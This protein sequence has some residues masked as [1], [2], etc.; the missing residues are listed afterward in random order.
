MGYFANGTQNEIFRG[1]YCDHCIH[2]REQD[3]PI[4]LL[5]LMW[6]YE[7]FK[8]HTQ[9]RPNGVQTTKRKALA[10][11]IP[12]EKPGEP[13]E[14]KMF[15]AYRNTE[16]FQVEVAHISDVDRLKAWVNDDDEVERLLMRWGDKIAIEKAG[17]K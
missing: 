17:V 6:N 1:L 10:A 15:Y 12:I 9:P 13:Q 8:S 5:H 16:Q 11:F 2:D 4:I 14:C 7:Q 3:C